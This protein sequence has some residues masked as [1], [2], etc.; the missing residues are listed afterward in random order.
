MKSQFSKFG[1][2]EE[3]SAS[4]VSSFR[5]RQPSLTR[6]YR[7]RTKKSMIHRVRT[8]KLLPLADPK[9]SSSRAGAEDPRRLLS[10]L[11]TSKYF[12]AHLRTSLFWLIRKVGS[13]SFVREEDAISAPKI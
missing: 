13:K 6:T 4:E 7:K 8:P 10:R 12:R 1:Q 2:D 9:E 5:S 11:H 3:G